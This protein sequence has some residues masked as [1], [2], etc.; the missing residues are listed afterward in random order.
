M[1]TT[2]R[3]AGMRGG[4]SKC[5]GSVHVVLCCAVLRYIVLCCAEYCTILHYCKDERVLLRVLRNADS[6]LTTPT[7]LPTFTPHPRLGYSPLP[8]L[9]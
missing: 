7:F 4:W 5:R 3:G 1:I 8:L 6:Q 2:H 9:H